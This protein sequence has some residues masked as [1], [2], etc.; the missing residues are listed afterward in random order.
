MMDLIEMGWLVMALM[1]VVLL[2]G[3][4]GSIMVILTMIDDDDEPS[5]LERMI[6]NSGAP[7]P[8]K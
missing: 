7:S 6:A 2:L 5:E 1:G 4:I 8:R 3:G